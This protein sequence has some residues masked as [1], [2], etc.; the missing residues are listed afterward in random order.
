MRIQ[1]SVSL[2]SL[3]KMTELIMGWGFPSSAGKDSACKAGTQVQFLGWEN[4]LEKG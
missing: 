2:R 1:G 4:P 3:R